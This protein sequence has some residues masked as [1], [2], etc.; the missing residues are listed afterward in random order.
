M[1]SLILSVT[2][3]RYSILC[4]NY[5][6]GRC[7]SIVCIMLYVE[8]TS[9]C[10]GNVKMALPRVPV[11]PSPDIDASKVNLAFG[12]RALPKL[13]RLFDYR[14]RYEGHLHSLNRV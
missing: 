13:V 9:G 8:V 7:K 11:Y 2:T 10:H 14:S 4:S 3:Y 12:D 5:T 1:R 6:W